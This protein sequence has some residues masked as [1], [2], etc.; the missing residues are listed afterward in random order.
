[1]VRLFCCLVV[2][3]VRK[4]LMISFAHSLLQSASCGFGSFCCCLL[5]KSAS[6]GKF[7]SIILT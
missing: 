6:G 4:H 7:K 5:L 2:Q 1:M 3:E